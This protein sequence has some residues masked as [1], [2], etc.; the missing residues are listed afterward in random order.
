MKKTTNIYLAALFG[1]LASVLVIA[2]AHSKEA[3]EVPTLQTASKA[4]ELAEV[5]T[6]L[7][8]QADIN[9]Q[10][11]RTQ[12]TALMVAAENNQLNVALL[13]LERKADIKLSDVAGK[14]ALH[15]AVIG[16]NLK[17]VSELL[18]LGADSQELDLGGNNVIA[19]AV[20][21]MHRELIPFLAQAKANVNQT[22]EMGMT[23]LIWAVIH[24]DLR[25]IKVLKK[26][27]ADHTARTEMGV[28]ALQLAK[29]KKLD[30]IVAYLESL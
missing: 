4:G 27:G 5:T 16:G 18:K 22:D 10:D 14:T 23:P 1:C 12:Q 13:L 6:L 17:L 24:K 9:A 29:S 20:K 15:Y 2:Q 8:A 25:S 3:V 11:P 21:S 30:D 28:D 7:D 26:L 19:L